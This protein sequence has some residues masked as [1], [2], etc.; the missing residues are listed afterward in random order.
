[1]ILFTV[2]FAGSFQAD[3]V[4]TWS[5]T[6]W[7]GEIEQPEPLVLPL[8]PPCWPLLLAAKALEEPT[9]SNAARTV[10]AKIR[11]GSFGRAVL[12]M[13]FSIDWDR[14]IGGPDGAAP[15]PEVRFQ[16]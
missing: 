7:L 4:Q 13:G 1:M 10:T 2:E 5:R 12:G 14:R 16:L 6:T 15:V 11:L 8:P 3:T 9:E